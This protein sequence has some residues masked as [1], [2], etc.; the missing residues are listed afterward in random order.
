MN[1]ATLERTHT[2]AVMDGTGDTKT[3]W[4]P[5][6]QD[7]VDAAR[8]TFKALRKKGYLIYRVN[9]EGN[10]GKAMTE[11]DPDAEKMIAVPA[12]VGG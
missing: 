12:I 2:M 8:D 3:I 11:F 9:A 5:N 1:T 6:N 7:E 4:N 10:K